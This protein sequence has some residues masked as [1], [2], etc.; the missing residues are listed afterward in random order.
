[1][2]AASMM[3][4]VSALAAAC[5]SLCGLSTAQDSPPEQ[6]PNI[7][8][9]VVDDLGWKD[10][11]CTGSAYYR[12]PNIDALAAH[13]MLFTQA[14]SNGP[15][16]APSRASLMTGLY[17]PWHR[18]FTVGN[19]ARGHA[20]LRKIEPIPNTRTLSPIY[21]TVA[22]SLRQAGYET[23]SIGKWHLTNAPTTHGFD[24]AIAGTAAGSPRGGHFS[25]YQNRYLAD[26][27]EGEYL[28]DRLTDEALEFLREPRDR[29]FFLY[30]SHYAVHAPIEA[31]E[32][33]VARYQQREG[34]DG[35]DNADYAAMIDSVDQS[36]GRILDHLEQTGQ[37]E[38]TLVLV[39][40]DNGGHEAFTSN[41]PLR[42]GKGMLYEGGIR[43]PL[44]VRWPKTV[45]PGSR[46]DVP[47]IG[48]DLFPTLV[49]ATGSLPP[50]DY[51]LEGASLMPLLT[52]RGDVEREHLYWHF[53]A[54]LQGR[55]G[56]GKPFRTRPCGVIRGPRYKL[57]EWFEDGSIELFD[58]RED[59]GETTDLASE[60]PE[61]AKSL[62]ERLRKWQRR[63]G[64]QVPTEENPRYRGR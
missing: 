27:P 16:C 18:M 15:N 24:V 29:P 41:A 12:T 17:P 9:F 50:R 46:S 21:M 8:L 58:L 47:V 31:K 63:V 1:M 64:A 51:P 7:V 36:L 33:I 25:P 22:E 20:A 55:K 14:Y 19:A 38:N 35:Q 48:I 60:E 43:V 6:R 32:D 34:A 11:G 49:E 57:I 45:R 13:G 5:M 44:I 23:A 52:E 4:T 26:G 30:L 61:V 53:P 39:T 37:A 59:P 56:S 40:S 10:L 3:H 62:L 54:Y 42:G 2:D 28:T